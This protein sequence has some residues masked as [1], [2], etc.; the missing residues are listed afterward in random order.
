MAEEIADNFEK[1]MKKGFLGT[2][3]LM[4]LEVEPS[5]G[6]KIGKAIEEQ[7]LGVWE[8]PASTLY[9][10]LNNLVEQGLISVKEETF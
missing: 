3:I 6:Y 10:V 8:P 4:V 2:F 5:H 9:T 7:T 1:A